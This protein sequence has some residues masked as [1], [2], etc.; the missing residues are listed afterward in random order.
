MSDSHKMP[1]GHII[2]II[3]AYL[4]PGIVAALIWLQWAGRV[5]T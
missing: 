3:P 2:P 1:T 4:L 5:N